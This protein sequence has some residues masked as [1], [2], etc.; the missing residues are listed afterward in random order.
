MWTTPRVKEMDVSLT[1]NGAIYIDYESRI[2]G[3]WSDKEPATP[4]KTTQES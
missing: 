3:I 2:T 1:A 4:E